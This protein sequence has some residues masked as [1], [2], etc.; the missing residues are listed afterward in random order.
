MRMQMGDSIP[1]LPDLQTSS[2]A[3][4]LNQLVEGMLKA[5]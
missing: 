5:R 1:D 4:G 3:F 2:F